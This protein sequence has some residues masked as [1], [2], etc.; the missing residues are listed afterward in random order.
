M[1]ETA[2]CVRSVLVLCL[3]GVAVYYY[4]R[5]FAFYV[6][7]LTVAGVS[8]SSSNV[9]RKENSNLTRASNY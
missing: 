2:H 4:S 6:H 5:I 7:Y 8:Q 9:A 3:P 1:T